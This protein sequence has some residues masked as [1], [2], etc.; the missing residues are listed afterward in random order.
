MVNRAVEATLLPYCADNGIGVVAYSPMQCG[1]LTGAFDHERLAN[2]DA[3]DWRRR[4]RSF[5][6]PIF[7]KTLELVERLRPLAQRH[8]RTP[9]Q[10]AVSWVLRRPEI[11]SAIVGARRPSQVEETAQAANWEL[12]TADID[13]IESILQ[14]LAVPTPGSLR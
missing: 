4:D 13:E 10:L 12:S 11:T 14:E 6:E 1:L 2:L 3:E 5:K 7:S 9:A 8:E